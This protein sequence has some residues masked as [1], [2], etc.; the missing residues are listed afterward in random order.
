MTLF[1]IDHLYGFLLSPYLS[2]L[3]KYFNKQLFISP[4]YR[5]KRALSTPYLTIGR[6]SCDQGTPIIK[7]HT[8]THS[9]NPLKKSIFSGE[10]KNTK[11]SGKG[12]NQNLKKTRKLQKK[13]FAAAEQSSKK[14]K[15]APRRTA[16]PLAVEKPWRRWLWILP[17]MRTE[18][19]FLIYFF[20][21]HR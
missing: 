17:L 4:V 9:T 8:H 19:V 16:K 14:P 3:Q 20:L 13:T 10:K 5:L 2:F 11:T 18:G 12:K 21:F 7:K 6:P 1:A 15:R